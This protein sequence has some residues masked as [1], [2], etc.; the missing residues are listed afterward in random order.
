MFG[1]EGVLQCGSNCVRVNGILNVNFDLIFVFCFLFCDR[2]VGLGA[3]HLEGFRDLRFMEFEDEGEEGI[4]IGT[5]P[6][7][8]ER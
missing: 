1:V 6:R 5:C 4:M 2:A 7:V 3:R 8:F